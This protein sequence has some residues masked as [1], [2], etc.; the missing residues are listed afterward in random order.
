LCHYKEA[1]IAF[2]EAEYLLDK[3][4]SILLFRKS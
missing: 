3:S 4:S 1:Q 2:E